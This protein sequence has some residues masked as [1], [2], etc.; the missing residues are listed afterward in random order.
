MT[1]MTGITSLPLFSLS[2]NH[3]REISLVSWKSACRQIYSYVF[4]TYFDTSRG[5]KTAA[6]EGGRKRAAFSALSTMALFFKW[7]H[8]RGAKNY[9]TGEKKGAKKQ[10]K[11]QVVGDPEGVAGISRSGRVREKGTALCLTNREVMIGKR[12]LVRGC[13]CEM[14]ARCI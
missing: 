10:K 3:P 4:F 9:G 11:R 12:L 5:L 2:T 8:R 6:W 1:G 7:M 13:P 14:E